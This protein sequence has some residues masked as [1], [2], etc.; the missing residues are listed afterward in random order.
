MKVPD[1]EML[2]ADDDEVF[3]QTNENEEEVFFVKRGANLIV[4]SKLNEQERAAF[5]IAKD[6]AFEPFLKNE[7]FTAIAEKDAD[8]GKTVPII[9]VLHQMEDQRPTT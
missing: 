9:Y 7:A 2:F 1:D 6:K 3:L 5:D 4:Q 8:P